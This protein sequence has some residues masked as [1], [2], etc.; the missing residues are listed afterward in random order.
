MQCGKLGSQGKFGVCDQSRYA[1]SPRSP[2]DLYMSYL[3]LGVYLPYCESREKDL[4]LPSDDCLLWL[5]ELFLW[6]IFLASDSV[7][8]YIASSSASV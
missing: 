5:K 1:E 3:D 2:G 8:I 6:N 7:P 4:C